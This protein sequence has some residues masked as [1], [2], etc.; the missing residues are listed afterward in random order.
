MLKTF[1]MDP[2]DMKEVIDE[3]MAKFDTDGD[4]GVSY[5]EF[6][7]MLHS[8]D[9]KWMHTE[10][11]MKRAQLHPHTALSQH[12]TPAPRGHTTKYSVPP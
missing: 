4:G 3:L 1:N 5:N 12:C 9:D 10:E 8:Y 11:R 7:K 6:A 2:A